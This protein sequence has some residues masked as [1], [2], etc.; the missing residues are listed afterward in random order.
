MIVVGG[1]FFERE[2][3]SVGL[4]MS[5][6]TIAKNKNLNMPRINLRLLLI[7]GFVNL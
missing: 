5:R 7:G 2:K 3:W 6:I 1:T 4:K